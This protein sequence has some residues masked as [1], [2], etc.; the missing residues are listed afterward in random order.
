MATIQVTT[1]NDQLAR[2]VTA[3]TNLYGY[4]ETITDAEGNEV[5]NPQTK[6]DFARQQVARFIKEAV[7]QYEAEEARRLA[8]Q[9][10]LDVDVT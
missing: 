10:V 2:A 5:P 7:K 9:N 1:P 4:K 3:L 6:N 8:E